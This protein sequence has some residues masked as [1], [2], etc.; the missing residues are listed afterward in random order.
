MRLVALLLLAPALAAAQAPRDSLR[1]L[2][3]F[4]VPMDGDF[5]PPQTSA[6]RAYLYSAAATGT[7]VGAGYL[8]DRYVAATLDPA[9]SDSYL[10]DAGGV[11]MAA[12]VLIGPSAGN[13][14]LGAGTTVTR[15][16]VPKL[17]GV[18]A[19]GTLVLVSLASA[20]PCTLSAPDCASGDAAGAGFAAAG[21]VLAIGL[22]VGTVYDLATIPGNARWARRARSNGNRAPARP[23]ALVPG[24]DARRDAPT[25]TLR[26]GI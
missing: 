22:A 14:S 17:A 9:T 16:L 7:L 5:Q 18:L 2:P 20:V 25:L 11:L 26:V 4:S 15:G 23:V 13:L 1:A 6:V 3:P 19:G 10:L 21:A 24:Y 8:I 12:G